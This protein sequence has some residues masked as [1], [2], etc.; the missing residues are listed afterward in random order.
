MVLQRTVYYGKIN[1]SAEKSK[2][3]LSPL[4]II[5]SILVILIIYYAN[6]WKESQK[7]NDIIITGT[8]ISDYN[9]IK[10]IAEELT[11]NKTKKNFNPNAL[12]TAIRELPYIYKVNLNLNYNGQ[13]T[14]NVQER[15][16]KAIIKCKNGEQYLLSADSMVLPFKPVESNRHIPIV[17]GLTKMD[18]KAS[19]DV[20]LATLSGIE[21]IGDKSIINSIK[22]IN[23]NESD[24]SLEFK[25]LNDTK[26]IIGQNDNLDAKLEKFAIYNNSRKKQTFAKII[27][28]RWSGIIIEI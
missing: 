9:Q 4:P 15:E 20:V 22:Q 2:L 3:L 6:S 28:L 8:K 11:L 21:N 7:I 25:L 18:D 24:K 1:K 16:I 13:L 19:I 26:V 27:D 5:L 12:I 10:K 17:I 14:I 23:F